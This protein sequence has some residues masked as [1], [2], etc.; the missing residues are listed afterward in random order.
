MMPVKVV[1]HCE[2]CSLKTLKPNQVCPSTMLANG[3]ELKAHD[4]IQ[5]G[6]KNPQLRIANNC[7][8][9]LVIVNG[10]C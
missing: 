10:Y 7:R 9:L 6:V 2:G 3:S 1:A 5:S 8:W 4:V